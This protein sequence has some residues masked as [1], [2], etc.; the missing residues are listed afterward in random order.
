[1][2]LLEKLKGLGDFPKF[3]VHLKKMLKKFIKLAEKT[4][5]LD[6]VGEKPLEV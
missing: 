2:R 4:D 6:N 3:F 5:R 1:M